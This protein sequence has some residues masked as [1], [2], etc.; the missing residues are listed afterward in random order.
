[1]EWEKTMADIS[2]IK[3]AKFSV[4]CKEKVLFTEI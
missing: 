4:T 2:F 1:V 3:C